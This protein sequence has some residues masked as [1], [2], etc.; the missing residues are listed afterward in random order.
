MSLTFE[1][2]LIAAVLQ[3]KDIYRRAKRAGIDESF[4]DANSF[5]AYVF[6]A[7]AYLDSIGNE[8]NENAFED[9][10]SHDQNLE[11]KEKGPFRSRVASLSKSRY[12]NVNLALDIMKEKAVDKKLHRALTS[13][14]MAVKRGESAQNIIEDLRLFVERTAD[15]GGE[16]EL[17]DFFKDFSQ[18]EAQ[19]RKTV[20]GGN[21]F[22]FNLHLRQFDYYFPGGLPPG[23]TMTASGPTFSGKSIVLSNIAVVATHPDN[24]LNV[25]YVVSENTKTLT[26]NR[27]DAMFLD[28]SY[29]LL[30]N[31][32][33]VT[34]DDRAF[35]EN[36]PSNGWG[37]LM[38]AKVQSKKFNAND[39]R[40][41]MDECIERGVSPDLLLIDSP[42]HQRSIQSFMNPW[43]EKGEVY[44]DNKNVA[45]EYG[46]AIVASA[47]L[48]AGSKKT[49]HMDNEQIAGS[50]DISRH[51]DFQIMFNVSEQDEVL[52]RARLVVTKNREYLIVD[53][54]NVDFYFSKSL[55]LRP[56][57][58]A[59]EW[60]Q[61]DQQT[62]YV[63]KAGETEKKPIKKLESRETFEHVNEEG[64]TEYIDSETGE[65]VSV[66]F[67]VTASGK[68]KTFNAQ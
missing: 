28:K 56:W 67:K 26:G 30:V 18:R 8:F 6:K 48:K 14:A 60:A 49:N 63:R 37:A 66:P 39:I 46:V 68:K 57:D 62:V 19:R 29:N 64:E 40:S 10:I 54:Q 34:D 21:N 16:Y 7:C 59:M 17:Y 41:I 23:T 9:L 2:N 25:V 36:A 53:G 22:K 44:L 12:E 24:G 13:S 11:T 43:Q 15:S 58:E 35:F 33:S 31:Q 45:E 3:S 61:D 38:I 51:V 32:D 4:F 5:N 42:D 27:L 1:D 65:V 20:T 50:Q 52:D 47:P 55:I